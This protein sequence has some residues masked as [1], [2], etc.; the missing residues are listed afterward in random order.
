MYFCLR[1]KERQHQRQPQ[2][3]EFK[4]RHFPNETT[5]VQE[6]D[7]ICTSFSKSASCQ[8]KTENQT[9]FLLLSLLCCFVLF[10]LS[11]LL[12]MFEAY[13]EFCSKF[14]TENF[15]PS[16]KVRNTVKVSKL[17]TTQS[18]LRFIECL[19][20]PP[21]S[22]HIFTMPLCYVPLKYF[23]KLYSLLEMKT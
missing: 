3:A 17:L 6:G 18:L 13:I 22:T 15:F 4:P 8:I 7:V 10:L 11:H 14:L 9:V 12:H 19:S 23:S 2:I 1:I 16:P 5:E 21:S 20:S